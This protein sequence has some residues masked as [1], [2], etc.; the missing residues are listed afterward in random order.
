MSAGITFDTG[1][2][3]ALERRQQRISRFYATA[4]AD[5]R[6]V[7]TPTVVI[8]EWWR[9]RTR[10]RERI[11][12]GLRLEPLDAELAKVAGEALAAVP[13]ASLVDAL[14]IASA[15]RRGDVLYTSDLEDMERLRTHFP[16]VRV[17]GT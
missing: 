5:G 3:I 10:V 4:V 7:T 14:V 17:L 16:G 6:I 1:A 12:A 13:G 15:A 2:L 8:G 11:V 9:G